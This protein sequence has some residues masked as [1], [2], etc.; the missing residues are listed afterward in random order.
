ME[1]LV[2][3]CIPKGLEGRAT[4]KVT[5]PLIEFLTHPSFQVRSYLWGKT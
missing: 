2:Q 5:M 3:L 4:N 1:K